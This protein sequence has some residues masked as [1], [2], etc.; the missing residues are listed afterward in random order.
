MENLVMQKKYKLLSS[1]ALA[2]VCL[3]G[4]SEAMQF[5]D[6]S[7]SNSIAN[8]SH[9]STVLNS[10]VTQEEKQALFAGFM[11]KF[12]D[13]DFAEQLVA[14]FSSVF[15]S[16]SPTKR[17]FL[18]SAMALS[19]SEEETP[20]PLPQ[21]ATAVPQI[22]PTSSARPSSSSSHVTMPQQPPQE[23]SF[24]FTRLNSLDD[25]SS[26][27]Q[28]YEAEPNPI[29]SVLRMID[30]SGIILNRFDDHL[31]TDRE[32]RGLQ[33]L[34]FQ[35]T[36]SKSDKIIDVSD[37]CGEYSS[38]VS[39]FAYRYGLEETEAR[40]SGGHVDQYMRAFESQSA[41]NRK[42]IRSIESCTSRGRTCRYDR[43]PGYFRSIHGTAPSSSSIGE[44]RTTRRSETR[45]EAPTPLGS[46]RPSLTLDQLLL[47]SQ[48]SGI[49]PPSARPKATSS[50]SSSSR[51]TR[52]P[53]SAVT[54]VAAA[55]KPKARSSSNTIMTTEDW[56]N[57]K[58]NPKK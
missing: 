16:Q 12:R 7:I 6:R 1:A 36:K 54:T 52:R 44:T 53:T 19:E 2:T 32:Y 56:I 11:Q 33:S 26:L 24:S 27:L 23:L 4:N 29:F 17:S 37:P 47:L 42:F 8:T 57:S 9:L 46:S 22:R 41:F 58:L 48:R 49:T 45:E 43:L 21:S 38:L 50:T 10:P 34:I 35:N 20:S 15:D 30:P 5:P 40:R 55:P 31:L 14:A 39:Y 18:R 25:L 28:H 13:A 51:N 3:I